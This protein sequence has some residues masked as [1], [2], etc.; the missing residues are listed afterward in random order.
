[1]L[2]VLAFTGGSSVPSRLR[3]QQY[4]PRLK[5]QNVEIVESASRSG[6]Y[7]P[8]ARWM[9]PAWGI[10]NLMDRAPS[11]IRSFKYDVTLLQRELLSTFVT[12]EPLM[13]RPRVLDIDDAIWVH[14]RGSFAKRLADMCDHIICGNQFLADKFSAWNRSVSVLPTPVDTNRFRPSPVNG[15]GCSPVI[16]WLGLSS[17]FPYLYSI[18]PALHQILRRY[19][20]AQ[21]RVISDRQPEFRKLPSSRVQYIPYSREEEVSRIQEMSIGIMPI[22]DSEWARGKCSFKMLLYMSCGIPVV[23]SRFG[24]NDEVLAKGEVGLGAATLDEW[25][26]SLDA[27]IRD[28]GRSRRMG[29]VGRQ[30]ILEH[31]SVDVLAPQLANTL[32]TVAA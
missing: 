26:D 2:K 10:W 29:E 6:L 8:E 30:V 7:P 23:V 19:P 17:G 15:H 12:L 11:V 4:I 9:R 14:R 3:V 5:N 25:V 24:M 31:Y 28:P 21:L 32:L 13:K 20:D 1:M 22:D 16:G 18:E 27:L